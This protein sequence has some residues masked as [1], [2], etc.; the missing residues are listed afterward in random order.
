MGNGQQGRSHKHSLS[1][2]RCPDSNLP[3]AISRK[4]LSGKPFN[5][6]FKIFCR[7]ANI[8]VKGK[9]E[10]DYPKENKA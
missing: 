10:L 8:V 7:E 1:T 2:P 4:E 3:N 6:I 9:V 5:E